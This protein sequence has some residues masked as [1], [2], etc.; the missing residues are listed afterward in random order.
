MNMEKTCSNTSSDA[1]DTEDGS[2]PVLPKELKCS[3]C[4][5]ILQHASSLSRHMASKCGQAKHFPCKHCDKS[6]DRRDSL[7]RHMTSCKG[8]CR[9]WRCSKC[10]NE[11]Q[12]N[13]YLKQHQVICLNECGICRKQL[14]PGGT[15]VCKGLFV[16][17]PGKRAKKRTHEELMSP[18]PIGYVRQYEEDIPT[19][20]D[21]HITVAMLL[22]YGP[23]L[24]RYE[25]DIDFRIND[26]LPGPS[27]AGDG[28]ST[29]S[30][31]A[32]SHPSEVRPSYVFLHLS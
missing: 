32:S 12:F 4:S 8:K 18:L 29:Q 23:S 26:D 28:R 27:N 21:S 30:S 6:F 25:A 11:F 3:K 2:Q 31:Q 24:E 9:V 19:D 22:E 20:F 14:E 5:K 16:N 13:A 1:V 7:Y 17:F 10:D 15:H